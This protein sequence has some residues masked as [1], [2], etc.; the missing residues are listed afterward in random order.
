[1]NYGDSFVEQMFAGHNLYCSDESVHIISDSEF[2]VSGNLTKKCVN[3]SG[4]PKFAFNPLLL[5]STYYV[6]NGIH[7]N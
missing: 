7:Q 2:I 5:P 1:M 4:P 3:F 6:F